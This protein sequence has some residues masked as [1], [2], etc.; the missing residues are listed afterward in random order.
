V[1]VLAENEL[2]VLGADQ[3]WSIGLAARGQVLRKPVERQW[4]IVH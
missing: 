3:E 1:R 4:S 2:F